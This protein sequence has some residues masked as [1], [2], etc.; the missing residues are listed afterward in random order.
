MLDRSKLKQSV[1]NNFKFVEYS[2]KFS[3]RV[4]NTMGKEKLRAI[5]PFPTVFSK[6]LFPRG[7]KGQKVSLCGKELNDDEKKFLETLRD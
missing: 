1:D 4:E 7:V 6:G 2:R 5:S 3:K